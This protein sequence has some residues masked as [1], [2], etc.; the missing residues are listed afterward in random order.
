MAGDYCANETDTKL[1]NHW[2][3]IIKENF[4]KYATNLEINCPISVIIF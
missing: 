1:E 4:L 2:I 3:Y